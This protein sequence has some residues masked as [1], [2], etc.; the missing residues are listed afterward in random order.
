MQEGNESEKE[1]FKFSERRQVIQI[2]FNAIFV[3]LTITGN[4]LICAAYHLNKTI[5]TPSNAIVLSMAYCDLLMVLSFVFKI[6]SALCEGSIR[7]YVCMVY[8]SFGYIIT[9][10]IIFHL[11]A[12]SIDRL[13][14]VKYSLRYNSMV[15]RA[16]VSRCLIGIWMFGL[17]QIA[18]IPVVLKSSKIR[19]TLDT[20]IDPCMAFWT[21]PANKNTTWDNLSTKF[22]V[23][24]ICILIFV[25]LLPILI[26]VI[27]YCYIWKQAMNHVKQIKAQKRALNKRP[28]EKYFQIHLKSTQTFAIVIGIF[29][30]CFLPVFAVMCE[31]ILFFTTVTEAE[32]SLVLML[33]HTSVIWNPFIYAWRNRVFRKAVKRL[34]ASRRR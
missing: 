15:S 28:D 2:T 16:R 7:T 8:S 24:L 18:M 34:I 9:S 10:L 30:V 31:R 1:S 14:A 22:K 26:I 33:A 13:L 19:S 25:F 23:F 4:S 3:L 29:L 20:T 12:I 27:S 32:A 5:R 21:R 17:F 11:C 6:T